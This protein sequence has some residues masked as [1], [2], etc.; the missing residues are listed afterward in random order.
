M[1]V[2][3]KLDPELALT[4]TV[5]DGVV[6]GDAWRTTVREI[7]ADPAWPPG[8]LNLTDLRTADLS[9]ITAADRDEIHALNAQYANKLVGM[10]SA[11]IGGANFETAR[12]F[13]NDDR[14]S[15]LQII[16]FDDLERACEWLGVPVP[17]VAAIIE[18]VRHRLRADTATGGAET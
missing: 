9:A 15:G 18:Q 16:P 1:G 17:A 10:K 3:Y 13:G 4:L 14:L 11:A 7:F 8:R 12:K 2:G 5:F 6:T